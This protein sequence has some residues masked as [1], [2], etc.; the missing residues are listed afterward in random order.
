MRWTAV[1]RA[2]A[3]LPF[4]ERRARHRCIV[5][6]A[7]VEPGD[8]SCSL[9]RPPTGTTQAPVPTP[10]ARS[11]SASCLGEAAASLRH[12]CAVTELRRAAPNVHVVHDGALRVRSA[13]V[14]RGLVHLWV[15][16]PNAQEPW[17]HRAPRSVRELL[18][19]QPMVVS[20]VG[21]H[22]IQRMPPSGTSTE[23]INA[24]NAICTTWGDRIG[25]GERSASKVPSA[26]LSHRPHCT[27]SSA[28]GQVVGERAHHGLVRGRTLLD[29]DVA[30]G[31]VVNERGGVRLRLHRERDR[32]I[33]DADSRRDAAFQRQVGLLTGVQERDEVGVESPAAHRSCR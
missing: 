24:S 32:E 27:S 17:E 5:G 4:V 6:T 9:W 21:Q 22:G 29:A 15:E 11:R 13:L 10:R 2:N 30:H 20:A 7:T 33:A 25:V 3:P 18:V 16:L 14:D 12:R 26:L 28:F 31:N 8:T 1:F 23:S 19:R